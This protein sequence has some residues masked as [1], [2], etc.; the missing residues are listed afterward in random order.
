MEKN[1]IPCRK[2]FTEKILEL[3]KKDRDIVTITSDARGSVTLTDYARELPQQFVEVGIAEQNATGIGAGMALSGKKPFVCGPAC[4]Y[5]SRSYE[6][7]KIDMAYNKT[8]VKIVAVSGGVSYGALG[9]SHHSLNDISAMRA[10]PDLTVILPC[11]AALTR[12]ATK[13]LAEFNGPVYMR[14][15]R[16]AV[17]DVYDHPNPEFIIGKANTILD[18]HDLTL[19]GTGETVYHCLQAGKKMQ[20]EGLSV[21]VLDMHTIKPLDTEAIK[22]AAKE[23]GHIIVV[24]EHHIHGGLGAAVAEWIVQNHPI[25]VKFIA[26][27]DENAVHGSSTELFAHYGIDSEGIYRTATSWINMVNSNNVQG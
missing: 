13:A 24:E 20:E 3:A 21:R 6:Q 11:D 22:K 25:P 2:A 26:F 10:L 18:G 16:G 17:P 12:E 23:T 14:L 15:G 4:F 9:S 27:P 7:V 1:N 19:I 5:S 8:N